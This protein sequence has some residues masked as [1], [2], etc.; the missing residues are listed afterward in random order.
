MS[1]ILGGTDLGETTNRPNRPYQ[2][3]NRSY[4]EADRP[5]RYRGGDKNSIRYTLPAL[6]SFA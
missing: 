4:S 2:L 6:S 1:I 5:Y 3:N